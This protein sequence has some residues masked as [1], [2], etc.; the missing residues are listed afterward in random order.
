[1]AVPEPSIPETPFN[2]LRLY[3]RMQQLVSHFWKRWS[4]EY[5]TSLQGRTKWKSNSPT[6]LKVG[7]LV[8]LKEP[9]LP[10]HWRLGRVVELHPGKDNIPRVVSVHTRSGIVK[11]S[12][13]KLCCL[14]LE[15]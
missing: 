5:I 11:R 12:V 6:P 1:M 15:T 13:L 7:S 3:Q 14:P 2:R 10:Q 8:L 4:E 9:T